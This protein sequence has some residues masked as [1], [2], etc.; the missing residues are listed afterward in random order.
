M[1]VIV[2]S[3]MPLSKGVKTMLRGRGVCGYENDIHT[4]LHFSS[5]PDVLVFCNADFGKETV[6]LISRFF[7]SLDHIIKQKESS[8]FVILM[9][10]VL[11]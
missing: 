6:N 10:S 7:S 5:L 1:K 11:V 9:L 8:T 4:H 2:F 3:F